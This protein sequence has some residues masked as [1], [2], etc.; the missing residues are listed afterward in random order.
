MMAPDP[1]SGS[2]GWCQKK[3]VP[4]EGAVLRGGA[5]GMETLA[6]S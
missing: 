6:C 5:G 2:G 1:M 3:E 4:L